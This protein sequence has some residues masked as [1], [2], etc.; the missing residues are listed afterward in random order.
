MERSALAAVIV[1]E[2]VDVLGVVGSVDVVVT[3]AVLLREPV[4]AVA[5]TRTT[6]VKVADAP[7][8]RLALVHVTVPAAPT[9]GFVHANAGPVFCNSET[10]VVLGGRVSVRET[11]VAGDGPLFVTLML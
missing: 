5:E 4:G 1:V 9:L 8:A 3:L 7:E 11:T 6:T 10:N 2:A